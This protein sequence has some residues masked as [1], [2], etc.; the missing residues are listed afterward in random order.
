MRDRERDLYVYICW[1]VFDMF[2]H[3]FIYVD[4]FVLDDDVV[5]LH[6]LILSVYK[7]KHFYC[8]KSGGEMSMGRWWGVAPA[9]QNTT[10]R[11]VPNLCGVPPPL[12]DITVINENTRF[13]WIYMCLFI[14]AGLVFWMPALVFECLDL[15]RVTIPDHHDEA[16]THLKSTPAEPELPGW[17]S[18]HCWMFACLFVVA[19]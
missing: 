5:C 11:R 14:M 8:W 2:L 16:V 3:S 9:L 12:H 15:R 19:V 1:Y 4:I 17:A 18:C 13:T 10:F 7:L 6:L